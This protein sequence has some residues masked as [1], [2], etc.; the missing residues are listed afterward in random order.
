[1]SLVKIKIQSQCYYMKKGP[2][3]NI[4][5]IIVRLRTCTSEDGNGPKYHRKG[6]PK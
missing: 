2:Y 5:A 6:I 1:M 3:I 4:L